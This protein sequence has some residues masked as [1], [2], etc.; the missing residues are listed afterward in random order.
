MVV[1]TFTARPVAHQ[2]GDHSV[3]RGRSVW[4]SATARTSWTCRGQRRLVGQGG[5][6][7]A[8]RAGCAAGTTGADRA[9]CARVWTSR[10]VSRTAVCWRA[11]TA[12]PACSCASRRPWRACRW[13]L[14]ATTP[15]RLRRLSLRR[16]LGA[17]QGTGAGRGNA[18]GRAGG[19]CLRAPAEA[20][21]GDLSPPQAVTGTV[22]S[23]G[24]VPAPKRQERLFRDASK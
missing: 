10:S 17:E 11:W 8:G 13:W 2:R 9:C 21:S 5:H 4:R 6:G 16:G 1:T 19:G 15:F 20:G 7:D 3:W 23:V 22:S 12:A 14:S 24:R 18:L